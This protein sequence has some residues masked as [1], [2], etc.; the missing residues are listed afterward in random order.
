MTDKKAQQIICAV[1]ESDPRFAA[2]AKEYAPLL[3]E[4][5]VLP[6]G[7][8]A[9]LAELLRQEPETAEAVAYYEKNGDELQHFGAGTIVS[10]AAVLTACLFLLGTH[11]KF[12]LD[13][14]GKKYLKIEHKPADNQLLTKVVDALCEVFRKT[15]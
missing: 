10:A 7:F 1:A 4:A 8:A 9:D 5:P 2:A 6:D 13:K 15:P 3:P 14:E 12:E 11:I